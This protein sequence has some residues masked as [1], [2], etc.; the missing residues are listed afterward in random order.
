MRRDIGTDDPRV[1]VRPQSSSRPRTKNRPDWSQKPLGQVIAIDRGRYSVICQGTGNR[2]L[3]VR[4]RELGR[5]SVIMGDFVRLTGDLSGRPDTLGRIV[6]V[7]DRRNVLRRSLEDAPDQR[8]EKAI[9]AH[10]DLMVIVTALADPPPRTGMIDRCLVAAYEAGMGAILC[11]TKADLGDP[12]EL[13]RLYADFDVDIVVTSC[14][15][16]DMVPA[17]IDDVRRLLAGHFS[18]LV[19]HSGVGK[20]TLINAL[21]PQAGRTVGHVNEV[22][23]RGRHTS[24]SSEAFELPEGG[25]IVD[26]PG[27]RSFGLGHVSVEDVLGVFPDAAQATTWCLPL[28]THLD[29]EPSCALDSWKQAVG[30]FAVSSVLTEA[31]K[32][33]RSHLVVSVRRLLEAVIHAQTISHVSRSRT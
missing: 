7:E 15:S 3:A 14:G 19:G 21:V 25:W 33:S 31:E 10:A 18:V 12:D 9:V 4:A 2:I 16:A 32:A 17:G 22:T 27:V 6:A 28:C 13:R 23:G 1:R 5:G 20:S 11:L 26:T 29:S 30:P 24:T 8:G